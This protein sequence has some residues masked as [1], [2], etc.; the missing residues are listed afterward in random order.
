MCADPE[1]MA[2]FEHTPDAAEAADVV[3]RVQAREARDGFCMWAL[4]LPGQ[5]PF[6]GFTGIQ[7]VPFEAPFGPAVEVGWRLARAAW[8]YGYA[9]EA[10]KAALDFGFGPAGL[11]E[12]VAM[13]VPAN[14]RSIAV[15]ERIGMRPDPDSAFDHPGVTIGHPL[16]RHVLYRIGAAEYRAGAAP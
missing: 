9:T 8:G 15:M 16:Q 11:A 12:I 3:R 5:A 2:Y 4:E 6:I 10:A 13:A 7:R 14:R 1:V